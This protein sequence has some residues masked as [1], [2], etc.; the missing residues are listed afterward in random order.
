MTIEERVNDVMERLHTWLDQGAHK[1]FHW[2][3][4]RGY[5]VMESDEETRRGIIRFIAEA[6]RQDGIEEGR[7]SSIQ[8]L[9][10]LIPVTRENQDLLQIAEMRIRALAK[11]EN[12]A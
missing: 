4:K 1:R 8:V 12:H 7:E 2:D 11:G 3:K 9:K 6:A 5:H 10:E